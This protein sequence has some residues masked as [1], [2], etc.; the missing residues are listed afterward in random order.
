MAPFLCHAAMIE[1]LCCY[2]GIFMLLWLRS[3][4]AMIT[5][6]CCCDGVSMLLRLR[7]RG[8]AIKSL[9]CCDKTSMALPWRIYRVLMRYLW[10]T[11]AYTMPYISLLRHSQSQF[12]LFSLVA[13]SFGLLLRKIV[14]QIVSFLRQNTCVC[15]CFSVSDII[16][17]IKAC[18]CMCYILLINRCFLTISPPVNPSPFSA[19]PCLI[20]RFFVVLRWPLL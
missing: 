6:P 20:W 18:G 14:F 11:N 7:C 10:W 8:S 17:K 16:K 3:R 4:A 2:D 12:S 5:F 15:K 13:F 1:P 9:C 19:L